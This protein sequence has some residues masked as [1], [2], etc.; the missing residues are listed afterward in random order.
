MY[1]DTTE[2]KLL[3]DILLDNPKGVSLSWPLFF[4]LYSQLAKI[5]VP[6]PEN[7]GTPNYHS[8]GANGC[9]DPE[10][11]KISQNRRSNEP[12]D[13]GREFVSHRFRLNELGL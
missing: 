12:R 3:S 9:S 2:I 7:P 11:G 1:G 4:N 13:D 10:Q 6:Y 8:R 5:K